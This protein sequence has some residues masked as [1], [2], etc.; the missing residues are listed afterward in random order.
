MKRGIQERMY[1]ATK[2]MSHQEFAAHI[3]KRIADSRFASFLDRPVSS[4][5]RPLPRSDQAATQ[6]DI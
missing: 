2:G 6:N 3:R 5:L 1:E 4:C